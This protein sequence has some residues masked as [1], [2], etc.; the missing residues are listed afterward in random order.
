M[1]VVLKRVQ[2]IKHEQKNNRNQEYVNILLIKS[3]SKL[4]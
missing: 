2:N 1:M 3:G 4:C